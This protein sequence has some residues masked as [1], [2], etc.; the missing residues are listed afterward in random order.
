[1]NPEFYAAFRSFLGQK[2][3]EDPGTS[4]RPSAGVSSRR[5]LERRPSNKPRAFRI[6]RS[7]ADGAD[8]EQRPA[9]APRE[10][11]ESIRVAFKQ[12]DTVRQAARRGWSYL[13]SVSRPDS[14]A[15]PFSDPLQ[16]GDT[17]I[18]ALALKWLTSLDEPMRDHLLGQAPATL[19]PDGRAATQDQLDR[20]A[21]WLT[22]CRRSGLLG[23]ERFYRQGKAL[24]RSVRDESGAQSP[25]WD[26]GVSALVLEPVLNTLQHSRDLAGIQEVQPLIDQVRQH[27]ES[28]A[29]LEGTPSYPT[30]EVFLCQVSELWRQTTPL[31]ASLRLPL[32]DA[33]RRRWWSSAGPAREP[34]ARRVLDL[35]CLIIAAE[36]LHLSEMNLSTARQDLLQLQDPQGS[37]SPAPYRRSHG[38]FFLGSRAVTTIFAV[39]ALEGQPRTGGWGPCRRW[40]QAES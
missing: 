17:L 35:S 31:S 12:R 1:M 26:V 18:S 34:L 6:A 3:S 16:G 4:R 28:G 32:E 29:Y 40:P 27:L 7:F 36:N 15:V 38:A 21:H 22:A 19:V 14:N 33:I 5:P 8:H 2:P 10:P 23:P 20:A 37:F 13:R 39:R 9:A 25:S 30:P 11:N 24:L